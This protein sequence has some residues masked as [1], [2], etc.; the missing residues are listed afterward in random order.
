MACDGCEHTLMKFLHFIQDE[1]NL[2]IFL[3]AHGVIDIEKTCPKCNKI[4][5]FYPSKNL[6]QCT[7]TTV[8]VNKHKKRERISCGYS[9]SGNKYTRFENSKFSVLEICSF[10]AFWLC[11]R[12]RQVD[13]EDEMGWSSSTVVAWSNFCRQVCFSVV[14]KSSEKL[15]G[16]G[17]T[18]DVDEAVFGKY[19][20]NGVSAIEDQWVFSGIERQSKKFFLIPVSSRSK[21]TLL[22]IIDEWVLPGTIIM[23]NC[24]KA[25]G[26]LDDEGFRKQRVDHGKNFID[27]DTKHIE[28]MWGHVKNFIPK[29]GRKESHL[30]LHLAEYHFHRKFPRMN[31]RFHNFFKYISE[32]DP[33]TGDECEDDK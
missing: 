7:T 14:S 30:V 16:I 23:S 20:Y 25:Y 10:V 13:L 21:E 11:A 4:C 6:F 3:N 24:W 2:K 26:C 18:V 32:V 28:R 31:E 29:N 9:I 27:P 5:T 12:Y 22:K 1:S 8:Q 33:P 15:G 17:K 19:K